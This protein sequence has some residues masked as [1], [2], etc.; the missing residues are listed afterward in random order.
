MTTKLAT[1]VH[2]GWPS[3]N[4]RFGRNDPKNMTYIKYNAKIGNMFFS[5]FYWVYPSI[6]SVHQGYS[7]NKDFPLCT[8]YSLICRVA[9]R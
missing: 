4:K 8:Q 7:T 1:V 9:Q 6:H 3:I 5:K 2:T